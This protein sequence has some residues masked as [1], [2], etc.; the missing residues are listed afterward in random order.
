MD[1]VATLKNEN[2]NLR[3]IQA[4]LLQ[5]E[6][7]DNPLAPLSSTQ[8]EFIN[9]LA[10]TLGATT[11]KTSLEFNEVGFEVKSSL[12]DFK[13]S[14]STI[15]STQDFLSWYNAVDGE[16]LRHFD[17]VYLDYYDQLEARSIECDKLLEEIDSLLDALKKLTNEY[18][19]VSEKTSSLHQASENLLQDQ[20]K[21]NEIGKDIRKRLKYFTQAE[22]IFQRL[23]NPTFSVSNDTFVDILNTIDDCL[24]YMRV[25]PSF[26]EA[27]AYTTKYR[28]C[29]SKATQMMTNYVINILANATAQIMLP[30]TVGSK[31]PVGQGSDAAFAL[32]YGKFQASAPKVKRITATIE[33]R[34]D[35]SVE[36]EQLLATLHQHFLAQRATIVS[37]DV[38]QAIRD[39]SKKHKDDHCALVRSACAFMVHVCQDEHRLF[40]QFFTKPSV[41]LTA[42]MEGLC[43]ILYDTLRP[44]IIRIDH[45]ETLAE[46]CSI[47]RVEMLDEHVNYNPEP[48]EAFAKIVYQLLQDVQERIGFRAQSYLESDILN[49]RPSA[50]DLAY[51]EKLEMME[52]IALSLQENFLRRADSRSSIVSMA[53][54]ASQEVESINQQA[55]LVAKSRAGNSPADLHG[56]WYPTVRR[57]LV[58]LSRL[59]RCIDR[60]IFQSLSQQA[61]TYCIQSVS[62]AAAQISQKKNS[63]DGALFE[64]KHLLILREQIAPFRVDFTVKETSLDFSKVKTAAFELLQKR[65]QLFALGSNNALLEFLLDGTPQVREQLLDSRK[66]VDRQ[67]KTVCEIFIRDATRQLVGPILTF[68][69]TAQNHL[70]QSTVSGSDGAKQQQGLALRMAPFAAPQQISSIIQESIR[71]IKTKLGG[72]QRSMQLYLANKDTE[73]ILFR[74][75]RNNII[76]SFVK[77][78]QLLTTNSFSKDDLI[79]V[80]CPSAEQISVLLSNVN[81]S[82]SGEAVGKTLDAQRKTSSSSMSSGGAAP[83]KPQVEKKVSFDSEANTIVQIDSASEEGGT[84]EA[85][86]VEN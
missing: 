8:N 23:Q 12:D 29:L 32:F 37:S 52:S 27:T 47:L 77:L 10:E 5:W 68:I 58:C 72:L 13:N 6:Q 64:I 85:T 22:S 42:Y 67:L 11:M 81:L 21:L 78:E 18:N 74:P 48:L 34:L 28:N 19:F 66:D 46:I 14:T 86:V 73:F 26:S 1:D 33:S 45:L 76:G 63:I 31:E 15:D 4:R 82:G 43:T 40:Y 83:I 7:K 35:R 17:D 39:L 54:L 71:N 55:E 49:Y 44:F 53:S 51:P 84:S 2:A 9:Q 60:V 24:E 3:K 80:S 75:I 62:S 41:Q 79:I 50:G 57:T 16:I 30:R 69:D 61:L 65:K 36:Y 38:E 70:K 25:N 56:M 20:N 59:Y